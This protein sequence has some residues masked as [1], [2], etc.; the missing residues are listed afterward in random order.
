MINWTTLLKSEMEYA[1]TITQN[2]INMVNDN[3][4][5]WKPATGANWMTVGQ[6]LKH[7]TES[8]G[9][10]CRGFVTGDWG[11]PEG[12]SLDDIPPEAMMPPAEKMPTV[13]SVQ[14]AKELLEQDKKV[15]FQMVDECG[16]DALT[17]QIAPACWD[18]TEMILG[19]R[20]LQMV[21]HLSS[22]KSQLFYYLKLMGK[23]VNTSHLW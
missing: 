3:E 7:I 12:M 14:E 21:A 8:C 13:S 17:N 4:L 10:A 9:V 6:L 18:P 1:Y 5:Q 11:L 22:H 2:L 15:A 16:E 20:L 23:P 19:H